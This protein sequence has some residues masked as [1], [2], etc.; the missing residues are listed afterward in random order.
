MAKGLNLKAV[1]S[2]ESKRFKAGIDNIKKQLKGFSGFLKSAFALGSI[3]ALGKKIVETG[4]QFEDSMA[5][6]QAVSNATRA[7]FEAMRAEAQRLGE[8]TRYTASEAANALENLTR[9]GLSAQQATKAL[10]GTL[11]LAQA[12]GIE[13]ANAADIVTN[14]LNAFGLS[15]SEVNRVND[16]LSSTAA[17]AATNINE[18]YEA[19]VVAGP[20]AKIMGKSVEEAAAAVGVLANNG[21]KGSNA[22]KSIAALF[23]RLSDITPKAAKAFAKYNLNINESTVKSQS[24]Y[25]TLKQLKDSGIGESV[26]DLSKA[27]GKNFAGNIAQLINGLEDFDATL[28]TVRNSAGTTERMF[29]QGVGSVRKELDT[30][31]STYE[32]FLISLSQKTSGPVKGVIKLLQNLIN[33]F[34]TVGGTI[35]NL[36]SVIVPLLASNFTKMART[37]MVAFRQIQ[38]GAVA[39]KLAIGNIAGVVLTLITWVGTGLVG[40]WNRQN[41]AMKDAKRQMEDATI[42]TKEMHDKA[43]ALIDKL[44]PDTDDDTLAGVVSK[45]CELFPDF[46]SA[47]QKAA[48][49]AKKTG[50]WENLKRVLNDIVELQSAIVTADAKK[51]LATAEN[52]RAV[53]KMWSDSYHPYAGRRTS[54][55]SNIPVSEDDL[56]EERAKLFLRDVRKQLSS[57]GLSDEYVKAIF[58]Q[59]YEAVKEGS[60]AGG[61]KIAKILEDHE[62]NKTLD[63]STQFVKDFTKEIRRFGHT[64]GALIT[65]PGVIKS[66]LADSANT[67][68]DYAVKQQAIKTARDAFNSTIQSLNQQLNEKQINRSDY[69]KKASEAVDDFAKAVSE[70]SLNDKELAEE[71]KNLRIKYPAPVKSTT[72][73]GSGDSGG[74]K[75]KK[76]KDAVDDVYDA[77][78]EWEDES[79]KLKNQLDQNTINQNEYEE[80]LQNLSKRTYDVITGAAIL[81]DWLNKLKDIVADPKAGAAAKKTAQ[82]M[83]DAYTKDFNTIKEYSE[84]AKR[85]ATAAEKKTQETKLGKI[86]TPKEKPRDKTF[87]YAKSKD[88][89]QEENIRIK[90]EYKEA[91]QK[92]IE[93]IQE[94]LA[95][96]DYE[97]IK[98]QALERVEQ[99]RKELEKAVDEADNL[100]H[101]LNLSK[102]SAQVKEIEKDLYGSIWGTFTSLA[103]GTD[104]LVRS[105][106]SVAQAFGEDLDLEEFEKAISIVNLLIQSV[107]VLS[108]VIK[109]AQSIV[110][111]SD[112][113]TGAKK[114]Q[115]AAKAEIAAI[116]ERTVAK[117]AEAA[118]DKTLLD[119][120]N[121]QVVKTGEKVAANQA[122][123][124]S[125]VE[126]TLAKLAEAGVDNILHEN[127]NKAVNDSLKQIMMNYQE[128]ASQNAK[129]SAAAGAAIG[130]GAESVAGVPIAG[131]VLAVGAA[132]S[133]AAAI[134]AGM[135]KFNTGGI[136]GGNSFTGDK[137]IVRANSGEMILTKGQQATLFNAI[138]SG[139]LGSGNVNFVIRGADLV[140]TLNNYTKRSKG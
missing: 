95:S 114:A 94:G 6:V 69:N 34:K 36:A 13:L 14:T 17:N 20:Y 40:A 23:Q 58:G 120:T 111:A 10:A 115:E 73:G 63:E 125:I 101:A 117:A 68:A 67:N 96:G 70:F 44:G 22:G 108:T 31:K 121:E 77:L 134:L 21:I 104:R 15:V 135:S 119:N 2:L 93:D 78:Q 8:T 66:H 131:P 33:N 136:V 129:A 59:I 45:L 123:A 57:K 107:E 90:L 126:R 30:L 130:E 32:G 113:L 106:Q 55:W 124:A 38:A 79:K 112:A 26:E 41:Q 85:A 105:L 81:E 53:E 139:N 48:D 65:D 61:P 19:M 82:T 140:G 16:V 116:G 102:L 92:A 11:Q 74:G 49:E 98:E 83:I 71:I 9:N 91:L 4:A 132:G 137:N 39:T 100:Q 72:S 80:G 12:N 25:D 24:L 76:T 88:D 56:K 103:D 42:K 110:E 118:L 86:E 43:Q 127:S 109:A 87:D 47:I 37:V 122:E 29:N 64:G 28:K 50:N 97:I 138:Q 27:F 51:A 84:K 52:Q 133:I 99:L 60:K 75:K 62:I 1:L 46:T 35:M 54:A 3:T 128:A 5:R 18:L 7:D 89:I